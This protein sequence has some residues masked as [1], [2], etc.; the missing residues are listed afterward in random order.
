MFMLQSLEKITVLLYNFFQE[1]V[2]NEALIK[3]H[4][5]TETMKKA[6]SR[7]L[8]IVAALGIF[9]LSFTSCQREGCPGMITKQNPKP[10][11]EKSM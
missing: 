1:C 3:N 6:L 8:A 11:Q 9:I 7:K 2:N 4:L 5:K 10:A